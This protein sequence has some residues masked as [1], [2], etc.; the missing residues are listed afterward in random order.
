M[1][2]IL[3][4]FMLSALLLFPTAGMAQTQFKDIS[5][6]WAATEI[7]VIYQKGYLKGISADQ[8]SP[9]TQVTRAELAASLDRVFD[10]NYDRTTEN[11]KFNPNQPVTR[12]EMAKAIQQAF[13]AK[14]L[15]VITTLMWPAFSD[16][17]NL[18]QEDQNAISFIYNTGIMKGRS[19]QHFNP[20]DPITRAELAVI[21][22]RT[23][24]TLQ[25]AFPIDQ[26][27]NSVNQ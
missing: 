23:L 17:S 24:D 5:N 6:H 25:I 26:E 11:R 10:F 16:T 4:P 18:S 1:K 3:F 9:D 20:Q 19:Y 27:A 13:K 21:L 12:L 22:N 7:Q 2:K 14:N 15:G 8:F